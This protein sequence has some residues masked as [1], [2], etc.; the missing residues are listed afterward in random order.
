MWC[1]EC[2]SLC[3][4]P[5]AVE[6]ER[7]SYYVYWHY[8]STITKESPFNAI[9]QNKRFKDMAHRLMCAVCNEED[10]PVCSYGPGPVGDVGGEGD[11]CASCTA[12]A[13]NTLV[14][15]EP[16]CEPQAPG[17]LCNSTPIPETGAAL[18]TSFTLTANLAT[19]V[20]VCIL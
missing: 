9:L 15:L 12:C 18:L 16:L 17:D 1:P 5:M 6:V 20:F 3:V 19:S 7:M 11:C 14:D 4:V 10:D 2:T 8:M 13:N